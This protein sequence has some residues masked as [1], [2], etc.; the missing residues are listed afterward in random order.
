MKKPTTANPTNRTSRLSDRNRGNKIGAFS[1]T[2]TEAIIVQKNRTA[3]LTTTTTDRTTARTA[4]PNP[5]LP[6]TVNFV[7][8]AKS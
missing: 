8:T 5:T 6:E 3:G 2:P 7:S 1:P 4:S